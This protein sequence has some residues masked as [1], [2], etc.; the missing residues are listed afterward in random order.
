MPM[1]EI[2]IL[3]TL[4][5]R[6][7]V[8]LIKVS[9]WSLESHFRAQLWKQ[10]KRTF[11]VC[12][13]VSSGVSSFILIFTMMTAATTARVTR[14][15]SFYTVLHSIFI[16]CPAV[17]HLRKYPTFWLVVSAVYPYPCMWREGFFIVRR[18]RLACVMPYSKFVRIVSS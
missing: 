10:L 13:T 6:A 1:S 11:T 15:P 8:S 17:P 7:T 9:C 4:T 2:P 14:W 5:G 18:R 12:Y 3:F 16:A